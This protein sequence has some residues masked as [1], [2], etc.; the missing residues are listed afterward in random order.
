M[1]EAKGSVLI[2][3]DDPALCGALAD[4]LSDEG[5]LVDTAVTAKAGLAICLSKKVDVVLLDQ[6]LPDG[7]GHTL[8]EP[9]L[10]HNDQTKIIFIT[11]FPSFDNAMK[12]IRAGAHNYLSKPFEYD[13][14]IHAIDTALKI[15]GLERKD[16]AQRYQSEREKMEICLVGPSLTEV[17]QYIELA[18][19]NDA[20]VFITGETGTGKN[21]VAKAIHYMSRQKDNPFISIN[22]ASVPESLIEAEFFGYDKGAYTGATH[23]KRGVFE[24]AEN[25][26]IF[27]DEIGEMPNHLQT[28]LLSV[29]DDKKIKRLGAETARTIHVRVI[30]A[31]NKDIDRALRDKT[32]RNDLFYRLSVIHIHLK[33]LRQRLDDIPALCRHFIDKMGG[34]GRIQLNKDDIANLKKYHWPGNVRELKN[35]VE[36]GI[37]LQNRGGGVSLSQLIGTP[38]VKTTDST[39]KGIAGLDSGIRPTLKELEMKYIK[40]MLGINNGNISK[41]ARMLSIS[42]STL[43]RKIK[44]YNL[45]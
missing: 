8:C 31:T 9:I 25:G 15:Q 30:A 41:T 16:Q 38:P 24:M 12:A 6:K 7:E 27:L 34:G 23:H 5:Y 22:C 33:P 20:P 42:L 10:N 40:Q 37:I 19:A 32:L 4:F 43:K 45:K 35:I 11:A 14:L 28:K 3:D 1:S 39:L 26:T 21:I 18:A 13:E 44:R 29:L 36:R 17:H 2:I